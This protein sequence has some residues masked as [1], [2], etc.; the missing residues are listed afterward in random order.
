MRGGSVTEG[1]LGRRIPTD[2]VHIDKYPLRALPVQ[3][4][5]TGVPSPVG[6]NW[7][8]EFDNPQKGQDGR[9][10]VAEPSKRSRPRGGHCVC[11]APWPFRDLLAW[12]LFY[13]QG[14]EGACVGFGESRAMS[15]MN[16]KRYDGR[17]LYK[18]AQLIDEWWNTPPEEGTSVRAGLDM[19]RTVGHVRVRGGRLNSTPD[20]VEGIAA[21]RWAT[22]VDDWLAALGRDGD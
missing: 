2:F 4:R 21:N 3:E 6:V 5:P 9:W 22:S 19:L 16:R 20:S 11:F 17:W 1:P 12:W 18:Q 14:R 13:N 7:Y 8:P 10:R 15:L